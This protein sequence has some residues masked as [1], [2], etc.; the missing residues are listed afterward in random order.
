MVLK[1]EFDFLQ[2][3]TQKGESKELATWKP[4]NELANIAT[5][6][7][8]KKYPEQKGNEIDRMDV[9]PSKGIVKVIYEKGC[10]EVQVDGTNGEIKSIAR[11]HADWIEHLHDGSIISDGF[12]LASMHLLGIGALLMIC[13]G[14]WLWYGPKRIRK[15]KKRKVLNISNQKTIKK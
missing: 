5:T 15:L 13:T 3:P 11:R 10:W 2:P 14:F 8:Y 7:F 9:R 1:K 12:K 4:I 6:A